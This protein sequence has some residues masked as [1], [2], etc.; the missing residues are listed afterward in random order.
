AGVGADFLFAGG[1]GSAPTDDQMRRFT[2]DAKTMEPQAALARWQDYRLYAAVLIVLTI[3][4]VTAH[5]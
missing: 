3:A 2:F 1:L 5:W 4:L